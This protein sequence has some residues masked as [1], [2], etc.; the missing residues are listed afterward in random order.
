MGINPYVQTRG[1]KTDVKRAGVSCR[2]RAGYN[3]LLKS[4]AVDYRAVQ[5][6]C[7]AI[8]VALAGIT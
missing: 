5:T 3:L 4:T 7:V 2:R 1:I 8:V 6:H